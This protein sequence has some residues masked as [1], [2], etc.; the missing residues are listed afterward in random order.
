MKGQEKIR[1]TVEIFGTDYTIVT[2]SSAVHTRKVA[3]LVDELMY[4]NEKAFPRL[5]STK[6]AV[7]AALSLADSNFLLEQQ[8]TETKDAQEDPTQTPEYIQLRDEYMKLRNAY[9]ELKQKV[10]GPSKP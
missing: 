5:D 7:L 10:N 3:A 2:N 9:L 4:R 1:V 8:I 6:L